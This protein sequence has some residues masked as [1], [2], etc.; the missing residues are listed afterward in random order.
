MSSINKVFVIIFC[1]VVLSVCANG[2]ITIVVNNAGT[3]KETCVTDSQEESTPCKTL[4][5]VLNELSLTQLETKDVTIIVEN[6]QTIQSINI[7]YG[8]HLNVTVLGVGQPSL[9][10]VDNGYLHFSSEDNINVDITFDGITFQNCNGYWSNAFEDWITGYAFLN[11]DIVSLQRLIVMNSS[12]IFFAGNKHI[13]IGYCSFQDNFYHYGLLYIS[14]TDNNIISSNDTLTSKNVVEHSLFSDNT[15]LADDYHTPLATVGGLITLSNRQ[16]I[17]SLLISGCLFQDNVIVNPADLDSGT[18]VAEV[19]VFAGDASFDLMNI[20][21]ESSKFAN[22]S[23]TQFSKMVSVLC[24]GS[25]F[26]KFHAQV[27]YNLFA[28]NYLKQSGEIVAFYFTDVISKFLTNI[29]YE[30]NDA[31]SNIGNSLSAHYSNVSNMNTVAIRNSTFVKNHG[32]A[33]FVHCKNCPVSK[34][35]V[36]MTFVEISENNIQFIQNGVVE[37]HHGILYLNNSSFFDNTGTGLRVTSSF[38]FPEGTILFE[39]NAGTYGG[40]LSMYGTSELFA[41][42]ANTVFTDNLA[43]YGAGLYIGIAVLQDNQCELFIKTN[44]EFVFSFHN[45]KASSSGNNV[46]FE[47]IALAQCI[48]QYLDDCFNITDYKNLGF[49]SSVNQI[50]GIYGNRDNNSKLSLFPGQNVIVNSSVYDAFGIMS[51]CVATVYLQCD[52]QVISCESNGELIQL[53]GPTLITIG[54]FSYTSNIKLLAPKN[55]SNSTFNNPSLRFKCAYTDTYT[56]Y[57]DIVECPVGFLYNQT[58]CACQCALENHGGF[59]CSVSH[60]MACVAKGYWLGVVEGSD[61]QEITVIAPCRYMY[62]NK[63]ANPCPNSVGQ[64]ASSYV[65]VGSSEN[66]QCGENH[67]GTLCFNCK[68]GASFSFEGLYC[69]ENE[70]CKPW[71]PFTI[72]VLVILFQ[73]VLAYVIQLFLSLQSFCGIGFLSGPLFYLAVVNTFGFGYLEEYYHL[74]TLISLFT[75]VFLL[76]MEVF[77]QIEWCFFSSLSALEN[78]AFHYLGPLIVTVVVFITV[79]IARK[80]P[81]LQKY[82]HISPIQTICLLLLLSFWSLSDTNIRILQIADFPGSKHIRVALQ[83]DL[84]YFTGTHIPLAILAILINIIVVLPFILLMLLAPFVSKKISLYRIQPLLDQFQSSYKDNFRWYPSVY[85]IGW[86]IIIVTQHEDLILQT[87]LAVMLSM[88]FILQPYTSKWLNIVNSL[89]ILDLLM[90]SALLNEQNNPFYDYT[91]NYWVKPVFKI[92][93]YLLIILPL[94]YIV[95]GM[96]HIALVKVN[97]YTYL[98]KKFWSNKKFNEKHEFLDSTVRTDEDPGYLSSS[99]PSLFLSK[100]SKRV[101]RQLLHITDTGSADEYREPLVVMVQEEGNYGTN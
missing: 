49:G 88:F 39:R 16:I 89:L 26:I 48:E 68:Y 42:G 61:D 51:S 87:V 94:L 22:H 24:V 80:C 10:C 71:Q 76:N 23:A 40:G 86:I 74:K 60:G 91:E 25:K 20:T 33:I 56:L 97:F 11:F 15:G 95:G 54:S 90:V 46:F 27:K 36:N 12:D 72:L 67:G 8:F 69:I 58:A 5:Y 41:N 13:S 45:N 38:V 78:Y 98:K 70:E 50:E 57:L 79:L 9:S 18:I 2:Y 92:L 3:D 17:F 7:S 62:C 73:F 37:I 4:H 21:I 55:I 64:D 34:T 32:Q 35:I 14:L 31:T 96:I 44:C 43:L 83:P 6:S 63:Q 59:L 53:E 29:E 85:M 28:N 101:S 81:K 30:F 52:N 65:L 93:V 1:L 84:P 19:E 99:D 77:G 66:D 75:S 100:S 47:D 82:L